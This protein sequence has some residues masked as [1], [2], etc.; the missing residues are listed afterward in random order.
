MRDV[1][2]Y[3]DSPLRIFQE[4]LTIEKDDRKPHTVIIRTA[5]LMLLNKVSKQLCLDDDIEKW[6]FDNKCNLTCEKLQI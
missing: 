2:A 3:V 5:T 6:Q 1:G 4:R